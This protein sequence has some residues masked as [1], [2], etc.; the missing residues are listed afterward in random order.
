MN[1]TS[2]LLMIAGIIGLSLITFPSFAQIKY[3]PKIGFNFSEMPDFTEFIIDQQIYTG[4]HIGVEGEYKLSDKL[5]IQ[6]SV[7]FCKK[8]SKYVVGNIADG[9]T[10]G[11]T[12]Y[13]FYS[14]YA[15]M[16]IELEYK[17]VLHKWNIIVLVGP[18]I[19]YGIAGKWTASDMTTS[20]IHFG[21]E[22]TDDF[23]PFDFGV[24]A[25]AGVEFGRVQVSSHF[26]YGM[27][28]LST[29]SP[30]L[31]EK[32]F[33]TIS[34]SIAYLFGKNKK[35]YGDYNLRYLNRSKTNKQHRK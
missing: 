22:S 13:Q 33:S 29:S 35:D 28:T 7:L 20:N 16:P 32:Q 3:G 23:K 14:F 19:G 12:N 11:F 24:T 17:Y 18:Q 25:G 8:G 9:N 26:Y 27:R 21:N 31:K 15:D 4:Y 30:P 34:I 5:F 2:R 6:S 1:N 10:E